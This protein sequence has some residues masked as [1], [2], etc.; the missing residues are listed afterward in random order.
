MYRTESDNYSFCKE[1]SRK[2]DW[3]SLNQL[4][5]IYLSAE[6]N[7]SKKEAR[8]ALSKTFNRTRTWQTCRRMKKEILP[9]LFI[10]VIFARPTI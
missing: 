3:E 10:K 9:A 2:G 7:Q 4:M 1:L 8:K 5:G 6:D